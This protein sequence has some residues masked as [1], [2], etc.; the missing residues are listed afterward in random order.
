MPSNK[1][2]R[3]LNY[4]VNKKGPVTG[5]KVAKAISHYQALTKRL[6]FEGETKWLNNAMTIVMLKLKKYGINTNKI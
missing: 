1:R 3:R 6:A 5:G 4:S 2:P